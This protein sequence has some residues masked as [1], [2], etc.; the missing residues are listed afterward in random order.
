MHDDIWRQLVLLQHQGDWDF[1]GTW[2]ATY[3]HR[4]G[5]C[6]K[7][8]AGS[9]HPA[10]TPCH[11]MLASRGLRV[12]GMYSDLLY[13][14][15]RCATAPLREE[16]LAEGNVPRVQ[17]LSVDAFRQQYEV[18][19]R[20]VILTDVVRGGTSTPLG[21]QTPTYVNMVNSHT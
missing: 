3:L 21:E 18:P 16:W 10:S 7:H 20:P 15:H 17:G 14:P 13:Q 6:T 4:Q 11:C 8:P 9:E 12:H 1:T 2:R 5:I 19:N